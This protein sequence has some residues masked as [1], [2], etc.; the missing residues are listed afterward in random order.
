MNKKT[1]PLRK[2]MTLKAEYKDKLDSTAFKL[3]HHLDER[4]TSTD[5]LYALVDHFLEDVQP[6]IKKKYEE[7]IF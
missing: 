6:L 7:E 4:V 3:S 2:T 1:T 5:V